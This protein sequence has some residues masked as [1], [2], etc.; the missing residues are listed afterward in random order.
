MPEAALDGGAAVSLEV[1]EPDVVAGFVG[2]NE[3]PP[4]LVMGARDNEAVM[5]VAANTAPFPPS[6]HEVEFSGG[7]QHQRL[8][9]HSVTLG[10]QSSFHHLLA[11]GFG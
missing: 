3:D 1:L 7:P 4:V 11:Q 9:S 8:S 10:A 2:V 5:A 6:Q